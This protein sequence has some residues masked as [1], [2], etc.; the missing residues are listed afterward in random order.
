[1]HEVAASH[2]WTKHYRYFGKWD[3]IHFSFSSLPITS[4]A[5]QRVAYLT[6]LFLCR[7]TLPWMHLRFCHQLFM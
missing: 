4:V 6:H 7:R 2:S 3:I 1:M 5:N